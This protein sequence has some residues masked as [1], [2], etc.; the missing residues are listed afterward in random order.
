MSYISF[1]KLSDIFT[2]VKSY[3]DS[4]VS[5]ALAKTDIDNST[6]K[7]ND[8]GQLYANMQPIKNEA[9]SK[10]QKFIYLDETNGDDTNDG[11]INA[12]VKT[13]A[14]ALELYESI[15]DRDAYICATKVTF[16][17]DVSYTEKNIKLWAEGGTTLTISGALKDDLLDFN[18]IVRGDGNV[19]DYVYIKKSEENCLLKYDINGIFKTAS[20]SCADYEKQININVKAETADISSISGFVNIS[21]NADT[22]YLHSVNTDTTPVNTPSTYV[23]NFALPVLNI[24]SNNVY[25]YSLYTRSCTIDCDRLYSY[26]TSCGHGYVI[27]AKEL[28]VNT[29][30][31]AFL[32]SFGVTSTATLSDINQSIINIDRVIVETQRTSN[33]SIFYNDGI[34]NYTLFVNTY[35][36]TK[37]IT[38]V[39]GGSISNYYK[40]VDS[41]EC[42]N[43]KISGYCKKILISQSQDG[44]STAKIIEFAWDAYKRSMT[45]NSRNDLCD[46]SF[47]YEDCNDTIVKVYVNN[48][49]GSHANSGLDKSCPVH[50]LSDAL[51][52]IKKNNLQR[53]EI[54]FMSA[55]VG[56]WAYDESIPA[57]FIT[58]TGDAST[59]SSNLCYLKITAEKDVN[60]KLAGFYLPN[61]TVDITATSLSI[62][63][64]NKSIYKHVAKIINIDANDICTYPGYAK[65]PNSVDEEFGLYG[66]IVNIK[67]HQVSSK[68]FTN[69]GSLYV[70]PRK[71][72]VNII[73]D[74]PIK[75]SI[76]E[77]YFDAAV[78]PAGDTTG[79]YNIG[80]INI[81]ST[82][83]A[84]VNFNYIEYDTVSAA[85]IN[86]NRLQGLIYIDALNLRLD[87]SKLIA[88]EMIVNTKDEMTIKFDEMCCSR[89]HI[90]G[91]KIHLT[92]KN[93]KTNAGY[94]TCVGHWSVSNNE[95]QKDNIGTD[96][97]AIATQILD[98]GTA[99]TENWTH[100]EESDN[101]QP[102]AAG[103]ESFDKNIIYFN[104]AA[105]HLKAS[106]INT[107]CGFRCCSSFIDCDWLNIDDLYF[108]SCEN[109]VNT[110]K[111]T[112]ANNT[113]SSGYGGLCAKEGYTLIN[114]NKVDSK[115]ILSPLTNYNGTTNNDGLNLTINTDSDIHIYITS[116]AADNH[117]SGD[118]KPNYDKIIKSNIS[119]ISN[120]NIT[121]ETLGICITESN[122]LLNALND[123]VF[124]T[125]RIVMADKSALYIN[126][127]NYSDT[128]CNSFTKTTFYINAKNKI[129]TNLFG[130]DINDGAGGSEMCLTANDINITS[131]GTFNYC[132]IYAN[133]NKTIK[134]ERGFKN[135]SM[136]IKTNDIEYTTAA[137]CENVELYIDA[138]RKYSSY[139]TIEDCSIF[140]NANNL[141]TF[142]SNDVKT[143][144]INA[145]CNKFEIN[146]KFDSCSTAI[147]TN[148]ITIDD[149]KTIQNGTITINANTVNAKTGA[150]FECDAVI[151]TNL[152]EGAL[153]FTK[154]AIIR[155][156][157]I[158]VIQSCLVGCEKLRIYADSILYDDNTYCYFNYGDIEINTNEI[159]ISKTNDFEYAPASTTTATGHSMI[160]FYSS[161][162]KT[163][164]LN[165]TINAN[166][167]YY[168]K[169]DDTYTVIAQCMHD[170]D[171]VNDANVRL[172]F[173]Q[174]FVNSLETY[175]FGTAH[176]ATGFK[177]KLRL[178]SDDKYIAKTFNT[179]KNTVESEYQAGT[180]DVL[181]YSAPTA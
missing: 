39:R 78:A 155:A 131:G 26:S 176:L 32:L 82:N 87:I 137:R 53:V 59:A 101:G 90:L 97:V 43:T 2:N 13:F 130:D 181:S 49:Y 148:T 5:T 152:F 179:Y 21:I 88:G 163:K 158:N 54:I 75:S 145:S 99:F 108:Y 18:L 102:P 89:V 96:F 110:K 173:N 119:V 33:Y 132:D 7:L 56:T 83:N 11:T 70:I 127:R 106:I 154:D 60:L 44:F 23:Y 174:I 109:L 117:E 142:G 157:T 8:F 80:I 95:I 128:S 86:F 161:S 156:N 166:K 1:D 29:P 50:D 69:D 140:A 160:A 118:T 135:G 58:S 16:D 6:I 114:A 170:S 129:T 45:S 151:N 104:F 57:K 125:N 19:E 168:T 79:D 85:S 138:L 136:Y 52:I 48:I 147:T 91:D 46:I 34:T 38:E 113:M 81:N 164:K 74:S 24:K 40:L 98:I 120:G 116:Q 165:A 61:A 55:N 115:F 17:K 167:L 133:A 169:T 72:I 31:N 30:Y 178:L 64:H 65:V 67:T 175:D 144:T 121:F 107:Y 9:E 51:S 153:A 36:L 3:I 159:S 150:T 28:H 111:L 12:K 77:V 47:I 171:S 172:K 139:A 92:A 22:T 37:V 134:I 25:T 73:S 149:W 143:T 105:I 41:I 162:D 4:K 71:N 62:Y 146:T 35:D 63:G 103:G 180:I 14:K 93:S 27:N 124:K 68:Y 177:G 66:D 112:F 141:I 20:K 94:G 15:T 122:V 84:K 123:V 76:F 126:C 10:P 42:K 100:G